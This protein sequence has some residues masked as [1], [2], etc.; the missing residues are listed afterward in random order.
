MVGQGGVRSGPVLKLEVPGGASRVLLHCCC[1]PC[2]GAIV[3]CMVQNG[4]RPAIFF[5]NSNIFPQEEY[6]KRRVEIVRYAAIFG[7]EVVDDDYCH[8]EWLDAIR[9]FENE[10]ERG[11]R[12]LECFKFRL[13]RAARYALA[14][15]Y[16]VL[17]TTLASSRWKDLSQVDEAGRWACCEVIKG[18]ADG[19]DLLWWGQNWRKGGL[20]PRRDQIIREQSFYNQ[21][22][23]GCEF[24]R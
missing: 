23:C 4:L 20:Q 10:P 5:S 11:A 6:V 7:L 3:E 19:R 17:T 14:N 2:S 24:C 1:A 12:C 9:G 13:L 16:E 8:E 21:T 15:G 18:A 22:F